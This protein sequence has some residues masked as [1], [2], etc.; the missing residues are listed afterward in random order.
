MSMPL[1]TSVVL[2]RVYPMTTSGRFRRRSRLNEVDAD[3]VADELTERMQIELEHDSGAV[4]LHRSCADQQYSSYF[5]VSLADCEKRGDLSLTRREWAEAFQFVLDGVDGGKVLA[6]PLP[7]PP[8]RRNA[9]K[10]ERLNSGLGWRVMQQL[11]NGARFRQTAFQQ[12]SRARG[13]ITEVHT[14]IAKT[15]RIE[16]TRILAQRRVY[17]S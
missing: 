6:P 16:R 1:V 11:R 7:E 5:L 10:G 13:N 8:Y 9:R 12:A 4:T 17:A 3:G 15:C 2:R 14:T